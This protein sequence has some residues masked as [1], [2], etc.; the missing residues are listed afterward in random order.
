MT[1]RPGAYRWKETRGVL[2]TV[3]S[4]PTRRLE[5]TAPAQNGRVRRSPSFG[6]SRPEDLGPS[7]GN[8]RYPSGVSL[9][10]AG[11]PLGVH[12]SRRIQGAEEWCTRTL[13][14]RNRERS[15][16]SAFAES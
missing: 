9:P 14:L 15:L 10:G 5:G 1:F 7:T 3:G 13:R 4:P 2:A 16:D 11:V 12:R 6:L 8:R